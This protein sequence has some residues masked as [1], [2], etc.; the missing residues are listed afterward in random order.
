[1]REL[2]VNE[3]QDVNGGFPKEGFVS[4]EGSIGINMS[5]IAMGAGIAA[6][7]ATAP[8]W[9]P[10]AMISVSIAATGSYIYSMFD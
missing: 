3:I 7:G 1:M 2:N 4:L 6:A 9:F 8:V 10:V 5:V